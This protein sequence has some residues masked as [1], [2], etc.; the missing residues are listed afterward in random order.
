MIDFK[1]IQLEDYEKL[2]PYIDSFGEH[3]CTWSFAH[4][5][6]YA[7]SFCIE[8]GCVYLMRDHL[9][10]AGN[11]VY[12][13]PL[14]PAGLIPDAVRRVIRD[15][16]DHGSSLEFNNV[17]D[18]SVKMLEENFPG[19]FSI[20]KDRNWAEY[21]YDSATLA[22]FPG[23]NF[24]A[25]RNSIKQFNSKYGN[26]LA[27][28]QFGRSCGSDVL[29]FQS[30]ELCP[31]ACDAPSSSRD[32]TSTIADILAFQE[33]WLEE[34]SETDDYGELA[35]ESLRIKNMLSCCKALHITGI[36]LYLE[37]EVAGYCFGA[38]NSSECF[39][40]I[41]EKGSTKYRGVYQKLVKELATAV[42]GTYPL[43]NREEDV[44]IEGL[45]RSK[46]G[47][48]PRYLLEKSF[49]TYNPARND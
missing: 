48:H 22:S 9:N 45:R 2:F 41:A 47:Y 35:A 26:A 43:I 15:A 12:M 23:R 29:C 6:K 32:E 28:R 24:S 27:V 5:Y 30:D 16:Q 42:S 21:I 13:I 19:Q 49:V 33:Q 46:L 11:R 36:A 25:I 8:D 40:V 4:M 34:R 3:S 18:R 7:D 31:L 44:G 20:R 10:S 39:D 38:P 14:G 1:T 17:T 37:D